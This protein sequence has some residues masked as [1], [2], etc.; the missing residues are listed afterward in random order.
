MIFFQ[1]MRGSGQSLPRVSLVEVFWSWIGSFIGI[2][3][4]AVMHL[5]RTLHPPGGATALIAVIDGES[6][7]RLGVRIFYP[8]P[9]FFY[10]VAPTQRSR[11][12]MML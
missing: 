11:S 8:L 1:K 4:V 12:W 2:T 7:H 5:T 3:A 6:V 9:C 10:I